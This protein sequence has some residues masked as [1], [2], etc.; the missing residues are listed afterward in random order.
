MK[1]ISGQTFKGLTVIKQVERPVEAKDKYR[2]YLCKCHYCGEEKIISRGYIGRNKSCGCQQGRHS[3]KHG[4]SGNKNPDR[5]YNIWAGIKYR[6]NN[7][8]SKDYK[9][10]GGRGIKICDE[11]AKDFMAF[12]NWATSNGYQDDLTI[13]R[14]DNNKGYSPENCRWATITEQNKNRRKGIR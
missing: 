3:K 4:Y 5:L 6:C 10:Y 2:Y 8:N 14:T 13:D 1:D 11:W 7:P 12:R 9:N